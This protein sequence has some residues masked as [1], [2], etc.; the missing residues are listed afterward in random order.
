MKGWD[1]GNYSFFASHSGA[2]ALFAIEYVKLPGRLSTS[3]HLVA[4]VVAGLLNGIIHKDYA[5]ELQECLVGPPALNDEI[6]AAVSDLKNEAKQR[7]IGDITKISKFVASLPEQLSTCDG[8][9]V[10]LD[11]L[12]QLTSIFRQPIDF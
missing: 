5:K 6:E 2:A 8:I 1:A 12:E 4:D 7:L 11:K 3:D 10:D 9:K